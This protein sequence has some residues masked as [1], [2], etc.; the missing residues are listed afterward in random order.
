MTLISRRDIANALVTGL[1][2]GFLAWGVLSYLQKALPY[3]FGS[4]WLVMVIPILWIAG[5]QLGYILGRWFGFFNQ[6]GKYVAIGFTNFAVDAGVFNLLL[7][8][9]HATEGFG[10]VAQKS[11]S[12]IVAVTHSYFWNHR[13]AFGSDEQRQTSQYTKFMIVNLIAMAINV[14]T[15]YAVVHFMGRPE[16][17]SPEVWA[18][19][20]AIAGAAVALIFNFI[21]FKVIVF[22]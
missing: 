2:A 17:M 20:G 21:G 4:A 3:D 5:V 16:S 8:M 6:F 7:S 18:N 1:T 13:W 22:K 11:A 9:T 15:T 19:I 10:L 12:F 14:G